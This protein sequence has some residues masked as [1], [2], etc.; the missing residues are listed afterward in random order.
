MR[1]V[2]QHMKKDRVLAGD[3]E[4]SKR[5]IESGKLRAA[6]EKVCGGLR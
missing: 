6:A 3:I 4:K 5:W 1:R 2:I